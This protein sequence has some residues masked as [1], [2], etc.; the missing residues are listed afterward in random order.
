VYDVLTQSV[1]DADFSL[2]ESEL[3]ELVP[4]S[5]IDGVRK[6]YNNMRVGKAL[7]YNIYSVMSYL[8]SPENGLMG[9]WSMTGGGNLLTS[10]LTKTRAEIIAHMLDD[11]EYRYVAKLDNQLN[12]EHIKN[13]ASC[14]DV[15]FYSLAVQ[16]GYMTFKFTEEREIYEIYIPNMEARKVWA[17]LFLDMCYKG[18]DNN[19]HNI[20]AKID[21]VDVFSRELTE[22]TSMTLSYNDFKV[23]DE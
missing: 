14:D 1:Y 18:I 19:L 12:M 11:D 9:Y 4:E 23:Q 3:S 22:F 10:L 5:E 13:I 8:S 16:A 6:W 15:S 20:F 2:T 7:L 17:R 21:K